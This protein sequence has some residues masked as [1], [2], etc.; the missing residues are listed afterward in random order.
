MDSKAASPSVRPYHTLFCTLPFIIPHLICDNSILT[1]T[2][3]VDTVS[4]KKFKMYII[5]FY[6]NNCKYYSAVVDVCTVGMYIYVWMS[7]LEVE[8]FLSV[9]FYF[10][11]YKIIISSVLYVCV[12][13]RQ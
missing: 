4:N 2:V 6:I 3:E 12:Y 1:I 5:Y 10:Y 8:K 9:I 7:I 11:F 13:R